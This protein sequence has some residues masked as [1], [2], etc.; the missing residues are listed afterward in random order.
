MKRLA[1]VAASSGQTPRRLRLTYLDI[2]GFGEPVRLALFVG[3]LPFEDHR[4]SHEEVAEMRNRGELP[5]GQVPVLDI[6]GQRFSQSQA[7]LR[8][9]GREGGLYPQELQLQCDVVEE[10]L[11]DLKAALKPQWYGSAVGRSPVSGKQLAPLTEI[12]KDTMHLRESTLVEKTSTRGTGLMRV[13]TWP[14]G[15]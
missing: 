3:G 1:S 5:F 11:V 10:A 2:K 4:V 14:N 8:W 6:D 12:Q 7:L 9:A 13:P 15:G